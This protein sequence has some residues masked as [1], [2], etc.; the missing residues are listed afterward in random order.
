M[1]LAEDGDDAACDPLLNT[2]EDSSLVQKKKAEPI[3]GFQTRGQVRTP[4]G[5]LPPCLEMI[6]R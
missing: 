2:N 3:R 6:L 4:K 5:N 1:R